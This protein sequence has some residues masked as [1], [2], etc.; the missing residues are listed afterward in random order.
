MH[1]YILGASGSGK[2]TLGNAL[3]AYLNVKHE[4][5]DDI[6]WEPT[7]KKFTKRRSSI[8][9]EE[10]LRDRL[11]EPESWVFSGVALPWAAS[12]EP[13]YDLVIFLQLDPNVRMERLRV[14]EIE[15]YGDRILEGGD[16]F[17]HSA[18]FLLWA[19]SYDSLSPSPPDKVGRPT[20]VSLAVHEK[21]LSER[22]CPVLR[23]DSARPID[24][25][26]LTTVK[27]MKENLSL[28]E[29]AWTEEI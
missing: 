24:E 27:F 14:R 12:I 2:T 11:N 15:R 10:V 7:E 18:G 1:I 5:A 16:R 29:F 3:S 8:A 20:N 25:L 26:M 22:P 13:L 17:E 4:D 6:F 9:R 21:W 28:G 23:L 19:K